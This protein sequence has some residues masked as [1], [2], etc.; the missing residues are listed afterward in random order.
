MAAP[1]PVVRCVSVMLAQPEKLV[2]TKAMMVS[3]LILFMAGLLN[4]L[5]CLTQAQ[6]L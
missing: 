6:K 2:A 4:I 5:M 1:V 3:V